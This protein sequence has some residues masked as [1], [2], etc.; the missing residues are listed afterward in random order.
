MSDAIIKDGKIVI[1]IKVADLPAAIEGGFLCGAFETRWKITNAD[2]FAKHLVRELN[3][4]DEEG[5]TRVHRMLDGAALEAIEQ[6]AQGIEQHED[7]EP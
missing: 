4:E 7:Q 3:H 5:T 2:A 1:S 6:G